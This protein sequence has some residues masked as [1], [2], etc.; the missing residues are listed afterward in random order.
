MRWPWPLLKSRAAHLGQ[1]PVGSQIAG[2]HLGVGFEAAAGHDNGLRP[3]LDVLAVSPG[4]HTLH[5]P[6]RVDETHCGRV[7]E[8]FDAGPLDSLVQRLDQ[9]RSAAQ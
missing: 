8:H 1:V 6:A 7:V 4:A 5:P 2:A 3:Q 9:L